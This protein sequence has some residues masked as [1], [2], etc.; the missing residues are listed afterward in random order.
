MQLAVLIDN[1]SDK[2]QF[3]MEHGL[4]FY[5]NTGF[6]KIVFDTGQSGAF[7]LNAMKMGIDISVIDYL[8]IS[9]GHFDHTGGIENFLQYN[10]HA[11]IILSPEAFLPKYSGNRYI[12]IPNTLHL[13]EKRTVPVRGQYSIDPV[14]TI[15]PDIHIGHP[16]DTHFEHFFIKEKDGFIPDTFQDEIFLSVKTDNKIAVITGCSHNGI[17]NIINTARHRLP[18]PVTYLFGGFHLK[19]DE[20]ETVER[21]ADFLNSTNIEKVVTGHCTGMEN[22]LILKSICQAQV[23]YSFSGNTYSF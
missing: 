22:Y 5:I 11:K 15:F 18:E 12:G 10:H 20:N 13:P 3:E 2:Q 6:S 7:I 16:E 21:T 9:H 1:Y 23:S 4:S 19:D 17:K 14:T 8:I